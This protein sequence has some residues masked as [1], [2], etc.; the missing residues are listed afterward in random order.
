MEASMKC[1]ACDHE[2]TDE[3][4]DPCAAIARTVK[5]TNDDIVDADIYCGV[6]S[7]EGL[8]CELLDGHTRPHRY[9]E[10]ESTDAERFFARPGDFYLVA[11]TIP[12]TTTG[13][14]HKFEF[15]IKADDEQLVYA[16]EILSQLRGATATIG[17]NVTMTRAQIL[18]RLP[19]NAEA[20]AVRPPQPAPEY[21][22]HHRAADDQ[23]NFNPYALRSELLDEVCRKHRATDCGECDEHD[24][25]LWV[26]PRYLEDDDDLVS[27]LIR[28]INAGI[29]TK[30]EYLERLRKVIG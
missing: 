15:G 7:A 21:I 19:G 24:D 29:M 30:D 13:S 16:R 4:C 18:D 22:G 8:D 10:A 12:T 14:A 27:E 1:V 6:Q 23:P 17:G 25:D 26:H 28:Q 5:P 2:T 20:Y 3:L 11:V 9:P